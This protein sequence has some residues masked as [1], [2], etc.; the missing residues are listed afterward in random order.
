MIS[1]SISG[2]FGEIKVKTGLHIGPLYWPPNRLIALAMLLP[3]QMVEKPWGRDDIA[4]A[5]AAPVGKRIGEIWYDASDAP[6]PLL[7]KWLFT[8]DKLSVQVH[9]ND[10]QAKARGAR[11]GKEECWYIVSAEPGACLGIGLK[12]PVDADTLRAAAIS[13]EIEH[14]LDWKPV[15]AGDYYY[16]PAGTVHAIGAG[17]TL[18]EL[19]QNAD[20]TYR[21]YDYQRLDNGIMR[22]LHL[23]DGISVS[24]A[25]PYFDPR[26]VR[27]AASR[28][29]VD[30][31]F[32]RLWLVHEKENFP[33]LPAFEKC[34][35]IP[36]AGQINWNGDTAGLG[37]CLYVGAQ[38]SWQM[39]ADA[40]ILVATVV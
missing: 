4:A 21:L 36:I 33:K 23:D 11:S 28:Q 29:L 17:V 39:S 26:S 13:G 20:I 16:I 6:L 10:M 2:C 30:G 8:S 24:K 27:S 19:Q 31:P 38:D 3:M 25:A 12:Q 5:F 40:K 1:A 32:F 7:A 22:E 35:I 18:V 15:Q 34:W 14:M 9:P 37:N